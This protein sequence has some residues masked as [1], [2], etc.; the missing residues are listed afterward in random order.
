M[1]RGTR[2]VCGGGVWKGRTKSDDCDEHERGKLS[3]E[4]GVGDADGDER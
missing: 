4:C 3:D 2:N 1:R